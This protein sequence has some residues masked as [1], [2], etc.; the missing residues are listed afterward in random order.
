MS[1]TKRATPSQANLRVP[2]DIP[3]LLS[4][5]FGELRNN[6]FHSGLDFKTQ[7]QT[8]LPVYCAADGYVSRVLVSPWGFGRAVYVTHPELG[9][10]TVYG[11]L[12]SFS[13]RIDNPTRARQYA[14]ETFRIDIEYA[15]GDIPVSRGELIGRS[16]N[17]GSSGGPHLHMDVRDAETEHALDPMD[18]YA[19]HIKDNVPPEV[20]AVALY[21]REGVV[22]GRPVPA[23][24]SGPH[25]RDSFTAWGRVVPGIKAYDKMTGTTNIYGVKYMTFIVDGDTVYRRVIDEFDFDRSRAVN[26]LVEYGDVVRDKSWNMITE[27]PESRPLT[28]MIYSRGDGSLM[29]D[30]ER[31]YKCEFILEDH[32][33]NRT[34]V[35]F[36]IVGKE[37]AIPDPA[38]EGRLLSFDRPYRI[39]EGGAV[40]E[41]PAGML[42]RDYL[43]AMERVEPAPDGTY[44]ALYSIGSPEEPLAGNIRISLPVGNDVIADKRKYCL[45]RYNGLRPSA[46]EGE[47][48]GGRMEAKV[49]RFGNY[50]VMAD[51]VAP[52]VVAQQPEKWGQRGA[53]TYKISDNLSGIDT[54]RGEIDGKWALMEL[55]GKTGTLSFKLD[56]KRWK[57]GVRHKVV[58]TVTD[59]CG[60]SST[61]TRTFTW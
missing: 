47:Y 26:T 9:L 46:V 49:N 57:K 30:R 23:F 21:P 52:K 60:N 19:G 7:G 17:A 25:L 12:Q 13:T 10:V 53:V 58:L 20:R 31:T 32:H 11:H 6:H 8:G 4:G 3:L 44:S 40:V 5:N 56:P 22:N 16:G 37:S 28:D 41:I 35:P 24:H 43:F 15:P 51:T 27:Q 55:D 36:S 39:E 33:G 14:E 34:R 48:R 45:V 54:Y 1:A 18:Y 61:D 29:I 38:G 42:Y 59:A 50:S 2:L